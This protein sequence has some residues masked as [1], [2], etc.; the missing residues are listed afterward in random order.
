MGPLGVLFQEQP[1][2]WGQT[3]LAR[4]L[5]CPHDS[6]PDA[7]RGETDLVFFDEWSHRNAIWL[8]SVSVWLTPTLSASESW[9]AVHSGLPCSPPP[10][11]DPDLRGPRSQPWSRPPR[12]T[13]H[14]TSQGDT[15]P[16]APP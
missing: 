8:G 12:V 13:S 16:S 4:M 9:G 14:P 5:F 15:V 2:G 3:R 10:P 11:L 7:D 6:N 1:G